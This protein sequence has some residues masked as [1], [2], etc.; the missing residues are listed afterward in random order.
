MNTTNSQSQSYEEIDLLELIIKI[1]KFFK[2]RFLLILAV[3]IACIGLGVLSSF[4]VFQPRYQSTM[5]FQSRSMTASEVVEI[6]NTLNNLVREENYNEIEKLTGLPKDIAKNLEKLEAAP[7]REIQKNIDKDIRKDSTIALTIET[8]NNEN[9]EK[10][11]QGIVS[12]FENLP[13]VQKRKQLFKENKERLLAQIQKDIKHTDSIK[14]IVEA[15]LFAKNPIILNSNS[16]FSKDLLLLYE[17]E[18]KVKEELAFIDDIKVIK[19][20]TH[21]QK[22]RKFS[23]RDTLGISALIGFIVGILWSLVIEF[24]KII[25]QREQNTI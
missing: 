10:I 25:R 21:Y 20:F 11:Q 3:M 19:G 23:I 5:I 7:N 4:L 8:T 9:L 14:R 15:S 22:P 24:N 18:G 1:Y 12:Y 2:K 6:T 17:A 16:G 13:Y